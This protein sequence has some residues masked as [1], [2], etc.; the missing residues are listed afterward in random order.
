MC[1]KTRNREIVQYV[2]NPRIMNES[3]EGFTPK[4]SLQ[5]SPSDDVRKTKEVQVARPQKNWKNK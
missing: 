4:H 1:Q 2:A 3:K 5:K